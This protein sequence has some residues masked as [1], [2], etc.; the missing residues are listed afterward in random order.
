VTLRG[1]SAVSTDGIGNGCVVATGG[2]TCFAED[3]DAAGAI[4]VRYP[5][6]GRAP[7][8]IAVVSIWACTSTPRGPQC[9]SLDGDPDVDEYEREEMRDALGSVRGDASTRVVSCGETALAIEASGTVHELGFGAPT[10][11]REDLTGA[12]DCSGSC[13]LFPD[14]VDCYG[15]SFPVAATDV[16]SMVGGP[17][18]IATREGGVAC[19]EIPYE[20]GLLPVEGLDHVVEVGVGSSLACAR[21]DDGSVWCW[22]YDLDG[23]IGRGIRPA[24]R[25]GP[26]RVSFGP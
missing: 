5:S 14:R 16:S 21:R 22:G 7:T 19:A 11:I 23:S 8:S 4:L 10:M 17:M 15:V 18:C 3:P 25:A 12:I 1:A 20:S 6:L 26:V 9:T 2:V 13:T 24:E